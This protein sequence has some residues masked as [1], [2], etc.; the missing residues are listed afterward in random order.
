[1]AADKNN[2][3]ERN[4]LS[5]II[6]LAHSKLDTSAFTSQESIIELTLMSCV[7][8]TVPY[9]HGDYGRKNP[10]SALGFEPTTF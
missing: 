5:R 2:G 8:M 10:L 3:D 1:M 4:L 6:Y 9:F 7:K